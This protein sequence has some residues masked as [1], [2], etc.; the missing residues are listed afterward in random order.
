MNT[1]PIVIC[2]LCVLFAGITTPV[3]NNYHTNCN[4]TDY[5]CILLCAVMGRICGFGRGAMVLSLY[6]RCL[7]ITHNFSPGPLLYKLPNG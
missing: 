2:M 6:L 1:L 4:R 3:I 5:F 7:I